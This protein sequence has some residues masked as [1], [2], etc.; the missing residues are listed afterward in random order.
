MWNSFFWPPPS[1]VGLDVQKPCRPLKFSTLLPYLHLNE[2]V[3]TVI[4]KNP[5]FVLYMLC[6]FYCLWRKI[7]PRARI[8]FSRTLISLTLSVTIVS[9]PTKFWNNIQFF[10]KFHILLSL[11]EFRIRPETFWTKMSNKLNLRVK[12]GLKLIK[13]CEL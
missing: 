7:L 3:C 12:Y 5:A 11:D 8:D 13:K 1:S 9:V 6:R 10:F 2:C 4:R